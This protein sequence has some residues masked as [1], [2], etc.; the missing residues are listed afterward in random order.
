MNVF[1]RSLLVFLG[2]V[3]GV[4][5]FL[6]NASGV[7]GNLM[8]MP[9][10]MGFAV[11]QTGSMEPTL[12]VGDLLVVQQQSA[13]DVKDVVVF[14]SERS[15]VVHRIVA[16]NATTFTTQGDA[17]NTADEPIEATAVKGK[18]VANVA[19]LGHVLE[20]FKS[21]LGMFVVLA[22]AIALVEL[23]LRRDRK[24]AKVQMLLE[25]RQ[26]EDEIRQLK[27]ELMQWQ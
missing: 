16:K 2:L 14:Q 13:Y 21:P 10:G 15:L 27:L 5:V 11:V 25:K 26:I 7:G 18:V 24:L 9:F 6:A 23:S 4:N 17:N 20:W 1:R 3:L 19:F 8:P 12:K 22:A